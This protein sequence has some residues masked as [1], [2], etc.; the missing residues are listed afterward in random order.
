[1]GNVKVAQL[2]AKLVFQLIHAMV[3]VWLV[4]KEFKII[5]DAIKDK[6]YYQMETVRLVQ[7]LTVNNALMIIRDVKNVLNRLELIK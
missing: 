7:Y 1:M 5:V 2:A 4:F 6:D 3:F